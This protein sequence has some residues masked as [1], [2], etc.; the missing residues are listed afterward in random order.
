[1]IDVCLGGVITFSY[2]VFFFNIIV[3]RTLIHCYVGK[4][5]LIIVCSFPFRII[6][7][8]S[9]GS[10]FTHCFFLISLISIN[11]NILTYFKIHHESISSKRASDFKPTPTSNAA[12]NPSEPSQ[13]TQSSRNKRK[14]GNVYSKVWLDYE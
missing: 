8:I 1:M 5:K 7:F 12:T 3:V 6:N 2:T 9:L 14:L 11:V 10:C 4:N 13:A